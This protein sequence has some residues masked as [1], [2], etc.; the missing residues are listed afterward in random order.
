MTEDA[1]KTLEMNRKKIDDNQQ[2]VQNALNVQIRKGFSCSSEEY[3]NFMKDNA[4]VLLHESSNEGNQP[5]DNSVALNRVGLVVE[6]HQACRRP[7][8]TTDGEIR[9]SA[10]TPTNTII[11]SLSR[12]RNDAWE[13]IMKEKEKKKNIRELESLLKSEFGVI[14][15]KKNR[16]SNVTNDH[17][18]HALSNILNFREK[19]QEMKEGLAGKSVGIIGGGHCR[20]GDDG[21]LMIP[22]NWH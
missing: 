12:L 10:S 14:K 22:W 21:S 9:I 4:E 11:S 6:T 7:V 20:L 5:G 13:N 2:H 1:R 17:Y 8:V 15:V 3:F 18:I 16:L 19:E